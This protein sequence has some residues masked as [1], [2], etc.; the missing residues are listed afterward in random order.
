[1]PKTNSI[2]SDPEYLKKFNNVLEILGI[3]E[4]LKADP[5]VVT[6]GN[7]NFAGTMPKPSVIGLIDQT[8]SESDVLS[9]IDMKKVEASTGEVR[10]MDI[11]GPVSEAVDENQGTPVLNK[12]NTSVKAYSCKKMKSEMYITHEE[13]KAAGDDGLA[14]FEN[15]L[16]NDLSKCLASDL[17]HLVFRG[18]VTL[19]A[20]SPDRWDRMLRRCNGLSV[21]CDAGAT[22]IDNNG[23]GV[24]FGMF[25]VWKARLLQKY[26]KQLPLYRWLLNSSTIDIWK[27]IFADQRPTAEGDKRVSGTPPESPAG[28]TPII[29]DTI[30]TDLGATA[31][32]DAAAD[33]GDGTITLNIN[34]LVGATTAAG[35]QVEV[36]CIATG[37]SETC[38]VT[39]SSPN[40][41]IATTGSLG[42]TTIST[43]AGDYEVKIA[44]ETEVYLGPPKTFA[45]VSPTH[46]WRSYYLYNKDY[47]RHEFTFYYELD[48]LLAVPEAWVKI[49][50]LKL[51][52]PPA[53]TE[54]TTW[55]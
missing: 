26:R 15:N 20:S 53:Y 49:K 6:L 38:T 28:V 31:A 41:Q 30:L 45:L 8:I 32:P 5:G 54:W 52:T 11:S 34:T 10:L 22:V 1:M 29:C 16:M 24:G 50:E 4:R 46:N 25:H 35:R 19:S 39:W 43:T 37:V 27:M 51:Q 47:D 36:T 12:P 42:Q 55:S 18:D 7:T 21:L 3:E 17:A 40:N 23:K 2:L 13:L 9:A 48:S 14:N 44:D 33:D